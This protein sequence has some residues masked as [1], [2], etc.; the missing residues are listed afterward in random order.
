MTSFAA[1][2]NKVMIED[3]DGRW[4]NG[5]LWYLRSYSYAKWSAG[6]RGAALELTVN[7]RVWD[8]GS[9]PPELSETSGSRVIRFSRRAIILTI[10][11]KEFGGIV[12]GSRESW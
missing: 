2:Y 10:S 8:S 12:L 11:M 5:G 1:K 4:D 3:L 6:M 9:R 7:V